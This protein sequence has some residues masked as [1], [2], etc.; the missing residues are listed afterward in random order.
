MSKRLKL[1]ELTLCAAASVNV[2]ATLRALEHCLR[3]CDFGDAIFFT[4]QKPEKLPVN[5]KWIEIPQLRSSQDYSRFVLHGLGQSITTS[6]CLIV[7]WDGFIVDP[8]A[9]EDAFLEHDYIGA[10][11]PQFSDGHDV[12]NGGFSLRSKRLLD[13]C[14]TSGF[15]YAEEAEDL[16]I[17]RRNR[18]WLESEHGMRFAD[19]ALANNFSFE[20]SR[21]ADRS[22]G[23]HGVFNLPT[24]VGA[25]GFW[26]IYCELDDRH[27][28]WTDF[29]L[30]LR[31]L[32]GAGTA[33]LK[34]SARFVFDWAIFALTQ[35]RRKSAAS[36]R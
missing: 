20:R 3:V 17:A 33:R 1:P 27:T 14:Q 2:E 12:G 9:W 36:R 22:F 8:D 24:V 23:F 32:L 6:H 26:E 21:T 7:Q 10:S 31:E 19:Q 18:V 29:S 5:L 16:L 28:V 11:W 4:H 30:L 35:R 34:R 13:A 15:V 25:D